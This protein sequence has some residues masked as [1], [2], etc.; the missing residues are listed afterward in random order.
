[1]IALVLSGFLAAVAVPFLYRFAPRHAGRVCALLPLILFIYLLSQ[2]SAVSGGLVKT[3]S[4]S[5]L[6]SIGLSFSLYLDGLGLLFSLLVTSIGFLVFLYTPDY[7]HDDPRQG[8][9]VAWLLA[10]MAAMLGT[11]LAGDLITLIVFWELTGICSY[12]LIGFNHTREASRAA[13]LQALMVTGVGGLSLLAGLL[14]LGHMSG[15][16][17]IAFVLSNGELIRGDALYPAVLL[18]LLGG[19][20]TK[21]AQFPFHHWLPAAMAA[22][23]PVSAYLH[24]ATMVKLGVFLL[25]RFSPVLGGTDLW[26][27]LLSSAG[28]VTMLVGGSL[29]VLEHDLKRIL[30]WSTVC[31]LGI[32]T[33]LLGIGSSDAVMAAMLFLLAH[34]LYKSSLFLMAGAVDH[35]TGSRDI[36]HLGNLSAQLPLLATAGLLATCSMAGLP[37]LLGFISKEMLYTAGLHLPEYSQ[38]L[39][40]ILIAANA[41]TVTAAIIA[42]L[43]PFFVKSAEQPFSV[44]HAPSFLLCSVPFVP[45][46]LGL[47]F[48]VMPGIGNGLLSSAVGAVL[49][50]EAEVRLSLWHGFNQ[51]L[52]LSGVTLLVGLALLGLRRP[53]VRMAG[54]LK[55][56]GLIGPS[57]LYDGLLAG[58]KRFA[59]LQTDLLQNG[60]LRYYLM[61]L[62]GVVMGLMGL[63]FLQTGGMPGDLPP[64][65]GYLYEW[66]AA[67]LILCG[68]LLAVVTNSR[69]A[70]VAAVGTV[71]YGVSL[72]YL[73]Y[74]APDLAMTQFCV[75]TL[76]IVLFVLVLYR[77]PLFS[78][79]CGPMARLRDGF[80]SLCIGGLMALLV[81]YVISQPLVP[82]VSEYFLENSL[83]AAYGRNVVNVILVDFRAL[84]TLGEIVVLAVAAMGV[85]ALLRYSRS[86]GGNP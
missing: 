21:S 85:V 75:E 34:G 11:V 74:G 48:G 8:E 26:F 25:A 17:E 9:L 24:S 43:L 37:P 86:G 62:I 66:I 6:P 12:M 31:A 83:T 27:W 79:I 22:P 45:A 32:L 77:L 61:V 67:V 19:A 39:T 23:T 54:R 76:S 15:S 44:K 81:L 14:L 46:L 53:L 4:Y 71:G 56:I 41:L 3:V 55:G 10:F 42:G 28:A 49:A 58:M 18:L 16:H 2:V 7:L 68:A 36:R 29:A 84:D 57:H 60:H 35:A 65:A 13:A 64:L 82:H 1:M 69:L 47:L 33:L 78:Q 80:M 40:G 38:F 20:F 50:T 70:A 52:L 51:E 30:A 5:W 73:L 63:T 59:A 72:I